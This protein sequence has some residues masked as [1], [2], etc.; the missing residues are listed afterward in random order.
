M[1]AVEWPL[2]AILAQWDAQILVMLFDMVSIAWA[3][4][5][6]YTA[7]QL[8]DSGKMKPLAFV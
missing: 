8:F 6:T 2:M 5:T 4:L 7:W 1:N 3:S